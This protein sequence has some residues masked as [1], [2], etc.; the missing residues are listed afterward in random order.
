MDNST[1]N[2]A[3]LAKHLT[4]EHAAWELIE[5]IRWPEGPTCPHC[6]WEDGAYYL[7]NRKTRK[8]EVSPRRLWKCSHCRKQYSALIG[9]IFERSHIPLSKWLLGIHLM[10]AGKNGVSAH[11]L[12]RQLGITV[13]SAWFMSHRIREAMKLDPLAGMLSGTIEA[14][15]TY[16][17]GKRRGSGRGRPGT[18]SHKTAVSTLVSR[19]GEA[20]SQVMERVTGDDLGKVLSSNVTPDSTLM[21]DE[22][23]AYRKP[24][25]MF[26]GHETVN[27]A[28]GEY[29]RGRV[30]TNT[31]EGYFSQ[32]K[33]SIDGTHHHV[34]RHHLPRYLANFDYLYSTRKLTD[35]ERTWRTIRQAGGRR[36]KYDTL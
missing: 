11:E 10:S 13:K 4:D 14:D 5:S 18:A 30:T 23:S 29:A 9:T 27:H 35:G 33:R 21:T 34:T 16:I 25:Q 3:E 7:G 32:L 17:G 22:F 24:G 36:L 15:E 12:S 2:L 19:D 31:V 1:L 20:R 6:G 26:A 8:G 28:H